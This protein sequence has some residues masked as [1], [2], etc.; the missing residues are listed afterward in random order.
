MDPF[1]PVVPV[2]KL[3]EDEDVAGKPLPFGVPPPAAP[4][5]P[6]VSGVGSDLTGQQ[7]TAAYLKTHPYSTGKAKTSGGG[8][9]WNPISWFE[10]AARTVVSGFDDLSNWVMKIVRDAANLIWEGIHSVFHLLD[11]YG[12]D[13]YHW[14]EECLV[15]AETLIRTVWHDAIHLLDDLRHDV[16]HW[17]DDLRHGIAAGFQV[18]RRVVEETAGRVLKD[19]WMFLERHVF[20]PLDTALHFVEH[21]VDWFGHELERAWG[22]LYRVFI[23]PVVRDFKALVHRVD[24]LEHAVFHDLYVGL[25]LLEEASD[26]M[27]WFAEHSFKD[28][29]KLVDA[30]EH[31]LER[32]LAAPPKGESKAG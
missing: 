28:I 12:T 24:R 20:K 3:L 26:W 16:S 19:A 30:G 32:W 17:L 2:G 14:A 7:V 29:G 5:W 15:R 13:I 31:D 18:I 8:I 10:S 9:D 11:R 22:E 27:I 6:S 25:H 1:D 21:A 23:A 4:I